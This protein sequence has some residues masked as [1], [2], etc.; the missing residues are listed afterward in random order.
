MGISE[1]ETEALR[2]TE[3]DRLKLVTSILDNLGGSDP[4]GPGED[5]LTEAI[6]RGAELKSGQV[7]GVSAEELSSEFREIRK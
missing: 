5:S 7:K 1:L 2:L 6:T 4:G 3:D